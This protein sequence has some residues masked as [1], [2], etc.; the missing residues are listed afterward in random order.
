MT[1]ASSDPTARR[2]RRRAVRERLLPWFATHARPLPWRSPPRDPYRVWVSEVMLQ[3]TRVDT[4]VGYYRRF[5]EAF[6][7]VE[8]LAAAREETV[9]KR[10]EGLGYYRRARMMLRTAR[11]VVA[12]HGGRFPDTAAG[13]LG[14]PGIGPYT[15]A[16]V[17]SL[18]F[19]EP[20]PVLDG[21][22]RRVAARLLAETGRADRPETQARLREALRELLPRG[23]AGET[24]EALMELG[25]TLCRPRAPRCPACPLRGVCRA[26]REG[27]PERFPV[28]P[29]K[30]PVPRIRVGAAVT[31]DGRGRVLVA[32][33]PSEAMLGGLW[34]FPGG[35]L[36]PGETMAEC[37]RRELLEELGAEVRVGG[38]LL[39]V[40][41]TYSHFHMEMDV[42]AARIERGRPQALGCAAVRWL[43]PARLR[44]L[45]FSRADLKVIEWIEREGLPC[46]PD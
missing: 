9:L 22:V 29:R 30:A 13:L 37:V 21:N 7:T 31:V 45:P 10:W 35:K 40:R 38:R 1:S 12:D 42:H 19:G 2:R 26:W 36:E 44:T 43:A 8:A 4:V 16:A 32:R 17:A 18:A 11:A 3:Q 33:R 27:D 15:A 5:L 28:L 20:V 39:T 46:P 24:N 41:H 34:E 23:R 6:P 25:A 14:L